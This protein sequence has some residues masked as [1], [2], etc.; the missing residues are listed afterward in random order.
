[1]IGLR[2]LGRQAH[3]RAVAVGDHD[4]V[5]ARDRRDRASGN[6]NIPPLSIRVLWLAQAKQRVAAE[7]YHDEHRTKP[8]KCRHRTAARLDVGP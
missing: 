4:G 7:S 1:M 2:L 3:L 6:R 8:I 5:L